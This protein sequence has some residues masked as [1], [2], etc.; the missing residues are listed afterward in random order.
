MLKLK[1]FALILGTLV[2]TSNVVYALGLVEFSLAT[3]S[4]GSTV[5]S[6]QLT[7]ESGNKEIIVNKDLIVNSQTEAR[8]ILASDDMAVQEGGMLQAALATIRSEAHK[9]K[10]EVNEANII[11]MIAKAKL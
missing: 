4:F 8:A 11:E 2:A 7:F 6:L 10:F 3:I 9:Q 1:Q 5:S